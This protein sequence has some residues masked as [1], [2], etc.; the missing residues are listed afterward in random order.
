M[1][2]T[3]KKEAPGWGAFALGSAVP[4][5]LNHMAREES[6]FGQRF[7]LWECGL[8]ACGL[9]DL[10]PLYRPYGFFAPLRNG[11]IRSIGSGKMVV[12]LFSEAISVSVCK[13]RSCSA[14]GCWEMTAEASASFCAA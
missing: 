12:E 9:G 3:I 2:V 8:G 5:G 1:P 13:K 10:A 14:I 11:A 6:R 7:G 4:V